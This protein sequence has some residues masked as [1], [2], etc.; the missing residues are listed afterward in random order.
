MQGWTDHNVLPRAPVV[1]GT[2]DV[3]VGAETVQTAQLGTE[4]AGQQVFISTQGFSSKAALHQKYIINYETT[5]VMCF[6]HFII[7]FVYFS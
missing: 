2:V 3:P 5:T 6:G 1:H 7:I 4:T